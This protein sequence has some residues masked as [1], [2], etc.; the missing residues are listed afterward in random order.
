MNDKI[1][2]RC[3]KCGRRYEPNPGG[4]SPI[5]CDCGVAFVGE[6]IFSETPE[7]F[8]PHGDIEYGLNASQAEDEL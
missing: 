2:M 3:S 8:V 1:V 5:T 6:I 4:P 7:G